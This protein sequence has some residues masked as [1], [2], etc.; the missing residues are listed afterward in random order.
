MKRIL[1][2]ALT[3]SVLGC[4]SAPQQQR[5]VPDDTPRFPA[6][7]ILKEG[8][9]NHDNWLELN[10]YFLIHYLYSD[11][12]NR[13]DLH[14][15]FS[16]EDKVRIIASLLFNLDFENP[17]N[18]VVDNYLD[19]TSL[20]VSLQLVRIGTRSSLLLATNADS[21]GG[22]IYVGPEYVTKTF[23]RSYVIVDDRL[24]AL[25]DLYSE[26]RE[27]DLIEDNRA[28]ELARFYIFDGNPGNDTVAEGL[29]IG[30][31]REAQSESE[32]SNAELTLCRYYMSQQRLAEAGVLL[33]AVGRQL[34]SAGEE[35][36]LLERY[37]ITYEEL[38]I[39]GALKQHEQRLREILPKSL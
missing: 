35:E 10:E 2:L 18:L 28:D 29:L 32:R 24:V 36:E 27:A 14:E 11:I 21:E 25:T 15:R 5:P 26:N 12:F 19:E 38:Q 6:Y 13:F 22:E 30:S 20:V 17:V 39:T 31:I 33:M 16:L 34:A 1:V 37:S 3:L 7:R 23:K 8:R 9:Q 4:T